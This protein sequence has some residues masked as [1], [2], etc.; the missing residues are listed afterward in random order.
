MATFSFDET[1]EFEQLMN[2]NEELWALGKERHHSSLLTKKAV[3]QS[4][5]GSFHQI[6]DMIQM[7]KF[8]FP[9]LTR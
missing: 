1:Q 3:G 7:D 8:P 9:W 5:T 2:L 6:P 4:G